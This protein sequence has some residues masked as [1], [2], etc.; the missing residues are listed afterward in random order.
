MKPVG[1]LSELKRRSSYGKPAA[2]I[3]VFAH[4]D[5]SFWDDVSRFLEQ[6]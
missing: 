1:K 4:R 6:Q 2:E 3:T 5:N